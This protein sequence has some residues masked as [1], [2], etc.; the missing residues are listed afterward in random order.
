V[1]GPAT[2]TA[3]AGYGV[4]QRHELSDIMTVSTGQSDSE[5]GA[6]PVHDQ[7][8]LASGPG[9]VDRRR[10]GVSPP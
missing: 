3:N 10:S 5:R 7:V 9:P 8:V 6:M 1:T 2:Q 4:Q